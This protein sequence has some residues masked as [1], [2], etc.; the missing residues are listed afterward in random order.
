MCLAFVGQGDALDA[1]GPSLLRN[2]GLS[3]KRD[4][5]PSFSQRISRIVHLTSQRMR[6]VV[7][8]AN[9][10]S[11]R[12][13]KGVTLDLLSDRLK[14]PCGLSHWSI[15]RQPEPLKIGSDTFGHADAY[16]DDPLFP[17]GKARASCLLAHVGHGFT[18][19]KW[20]RPVG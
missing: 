19:L 7:K 12:R 18:P 3:F 5:G 13:A 15:A 16:A 2:P 1:I 6:Q 9:P 8:V 11:H 14:D 17:V 10:P 20:G 4:V